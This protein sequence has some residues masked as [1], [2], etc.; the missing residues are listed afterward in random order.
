[1]SH[2]DSFLE[3]ITGRSRGRGRCFG[4]GSRTWCLGFVNPRAQSPGAEPTLA[5]FPSLPRGS[6]AETCPSTSAVPKLRT[7]GLELFSKRLAA[8][9]WEDGSSGGSTSGSFTSGMGRET[10]SNSSTRPVRDSISPAVLPV[11]S[12]HRLEDRGTGDGNFPGV[13]KDVANKFAAACDCC[14]SNRE[15]FRVSLGL[16]TSGV[17]GVPGTEGIGLMRVRFGLDG[18]FRVYRLAERCVAGFGKPL[19]GFHLIWAALSGV[20]GVPTPEEGK[21]VTPVVPTLAENKGLKALGVSGNVWRSA[22]AVVG[23]PSEIPSKESR[24]SRTTLMGCGRDVSEGAEGINMKSRISGEE[25][26]DERGSDAARLAPSVD[27]RDSSDLREKG[28]EG[29]CRERGRSLPIGRRPGREGPLCLWPGP[30]WSVK[31]RFMSNTLRPGIQQRQARGIPGNTKRP[32]VPRS[33]S[34]GLWCLRKRR[35][36]RGAALVSPVGS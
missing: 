7:F 30:V 29:T 20:P 32:T 2:V 18:V 15:F 4:A 36:R 21:G 24:L 12:E 28:D 19:L 13:T 3:P 27:R 10:S 9:R 23:D 1:M 11:G 14:A 22:S 34:P 8:N 5:L 31:T 25:I 6:V 26:P 16:R 35:G 33:L 17:W